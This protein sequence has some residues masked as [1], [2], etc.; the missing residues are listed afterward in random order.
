MQSV[1]GVFRSRTDAEVVVGDLVNHGVPQ[2]SIILLSSDQSSLR[3]LGGGKGDGDEAVEEKLESMPTTD[4]EADGM[5]KSVGALMGGGVGATLGWAAGAAVANLLVPGVG[6]IF[7]LGLGGAALLG[8][9]GAVAGAEV[10]DVTEH[11]LDTGVPKDDVI[12]Y[13]Q[14]LKEGRSLIVVNVDDEDLAKTAKSVMKEQG[15]ET[16]DQVR[17]QLHPAA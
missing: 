15:G 17:N 11:A 10:G 8:L 2:P 12:L 6:T 14:L 9:G 1:T 7:T 5:G 4:A 3:G 16:P 13:R